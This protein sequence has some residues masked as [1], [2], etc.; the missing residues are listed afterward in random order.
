[1]TYWALIFAFT[2]IT[3]I[4]FRLVRSVS[5]CRLER[6]LPIN[7][8]ERQVHLGGHSAVAV[9]RAGPRARPQR[10]GQP[11]RAPDH[12][13][14]QTGLL[15]LGR[16]RDVAGAAGP[17]VLLQPQ[18]GHLVHGEQIPRAGGGAQVRAQLLREPRAGAQHP[19]CV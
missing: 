5:S 12:G 4:S 11:C 17:G 10:R 6:S 14:V 19:D 8:S 13:G 18:G 7:Q 15:R 16:V 1:M 9:L 2:I 3:S